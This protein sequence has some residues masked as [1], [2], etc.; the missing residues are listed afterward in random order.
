[1]DGDAGHDH[2]SRPGRAPRPSD[3]KACPEDDKYCP[4]F[5]IRA[6]FDTAW[7]QKQT[8][9]PVRL[10]WSEVPCAPRAIL[11][12][13]QAVDLM[14]GNAMRATT[15]EVLHHAAH[16]APANDLTSFEGCMFACL[17]GPTVAHLV[18]VMNSHLRAQGFPI[19]HAG[20]FMCF[21]GVLMLRLAFRTWYHDVM[22]DMDAWTWSHA[23][24]YE[25]YKQLSACLRLQHSGMGS[26]AEVRVLVWSW[27]AL[28]CKRLTIGCRLVAPR[29]VWRVCEPLSTSC[30]RT[31]GGCC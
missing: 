3:D 7:R 24:P 15:K 25:R 27:V 12:D 30:S 22:S 19:T 13:E 4:G 17:D 26:S 1:M 2:R 6:G 9:P 16:A 29:H 31:S 5:R 11:S 14:V 8:S 23:P 10:S 28:C 21:V 18:D 20:E